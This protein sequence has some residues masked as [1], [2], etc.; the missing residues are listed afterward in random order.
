[1]EPKQE[2]LTK[3]PVPADNPQAELLREGA[4]IVRLENNT[5]MQIAVQRPRD[6]AKIL[7]DALKELDL[8]PS[9]AEEVMYSKPVGKDDNGK[10]KYAEGL[11]IRTA[12][13]LA[14]RWSNSAFGCEI[15]TEDEQGVILAAVFL[16][17]EA[18]TRHVVQKKVS[19]YYKAK[20][21][22]KRLHPP[23]RF[24][25][26]VIPA[27]QSK[28]LREVI[29]RSLPAGLKK[30]YEEKARKILGS[31]DKMKR[32]TKL[33]AGFLRLG[34][35][36]SKLEELAG[37]K[38]D[39]LTPEE[40]TDLIGVGNAIRDG[41]TTIEQLIVEKTAGEKLADRMGNGTAKPAEDQK[42]LETPTGAG[43]TGMRLSLYEKVADMAAGD[44]LEMNKILT[45]LSGGKIKSK[46]DL[47]GAADKLVQEMIDKFTGGK[48][49]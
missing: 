17:Y 9:M 21:G 22:E 37:K 23:D 44:I 4:A 7:S 31:G 41:E 24:T 29:L 34:V 5:Q 48:K 49:S 14:N 19:R 42:P 47:V 18:N 26:I 45:T 6:E 20:T 40:I 12:E 8:Y 28:L 38:V 25:D 27:N 1:M 15:V 16:D 35:S 3:L 33:V 10:M 30:E 36:K 11:S 46:D 2:V 32:S 39:D 13:S 43:L